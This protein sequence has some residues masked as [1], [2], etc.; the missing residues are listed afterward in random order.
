MKFTL[1]VI[2][3]G[4]GAALAVIFAPRSGEETRAMISNKAREG[5]R[6]AEERARDIRD[7]AGDK[8]SQLRDLAND[9]V[10]RGKKAIEKPRNAF[11]AAI[12]AGKEAYNREAH[13]AA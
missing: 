8:T 2:G 11:S 4:A 6:Y 13:R 12:R 7:M 9:A 3:M 10:E 1:F 5:R